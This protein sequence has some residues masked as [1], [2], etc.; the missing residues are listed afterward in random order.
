MTDTTRCLVA[1][2]VSILS[3]FAERQT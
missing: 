2:K 1:V 3:P